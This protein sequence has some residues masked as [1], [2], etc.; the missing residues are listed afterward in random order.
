LDIESTANRIHNAAE[1]S[2]QPVASVLDKPPTVLSD[3]RI[4]KRA[5]VALEMGVS[6]LFVEAS[7]PAVASHIGRQDGG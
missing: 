7:Q 4:D 6:A 3:F 2:Q 1:L 5:Q